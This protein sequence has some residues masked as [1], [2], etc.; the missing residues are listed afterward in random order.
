MPYG[1]LAPAVNALLSRHVDMAFAELAL[2]GAHA[3]SGTLR[4]LGTPASSRFAAA[5][6]LP[7]LREQG[8][9]DVVIDAWTGARRTGWRFR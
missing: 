3:K 6:E 8:L 4:L 2:V 7:T 1:G 5:P 9:P